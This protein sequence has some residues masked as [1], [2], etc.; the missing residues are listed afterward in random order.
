MIF[1]RLFKIHN[2]WFNLKIHPNSTLLPIILLITKDAVSPI[3]KDRQRPERDREATHEVKLANS[4]FFNQTLAGQQMGL[5]RISLDQFGPNLEVT[6]LPV[7]RSS[8][9]QADKHMF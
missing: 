5:I 1:A 6:R 4:P 9:G 7:G 2:S 8:V 3:V